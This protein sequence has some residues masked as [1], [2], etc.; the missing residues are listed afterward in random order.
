MSAVAAGPRAVRVAF[1]ARQGADPSRR[2]LGLTAKL[3]SGI[4]VASLFPASA[5]AAGPIASS[6]FIGT[7]D[8]LLENGAWAA[9]TSLSPNG[10]RFQKNNGAFPDKPGPD[11]A[12]A[13]T[14]AAVPVDQFSEIVVGHVG[15]TNNN[16]GPIVRVQASGPSIDSH[17]LWWTSQPNGVSGLYRIDANGTS[18]GSAR[19]LGSSSVVD[20]DRLRL[21][22]RGPVIYGV[23]NGARE[24][25]Y[26]TGPDTVKYSTGTTGMLAWAGNGVVTDSRI[27]SWSTDAAPVSLGTWA[28]S[29]FTGVE[30]PLDETDR[31]Y[32]LPGYSGFRKAGVA[33]GKDGAHTASGVWSIAP[34]AKQ[35]SEVTLGTVARGGGGP[36]VRIDRTNN[37]QTGWL[38]FLAPENLSLS[39][40]YKMNPDGSFTGVRLFTP[41]IV[42]GDKW[43]LT[44]DGNTLEAFRNGVSQFTYTTDGSYAAGD[45]GIEAYTS[46][47]TF[48]AWEG[49]DTGGGDA[50]PPSQP[51]NLGATAVS[52]SQINLGWT[53]S[54]DNV[55]VSG[56]LVERCP[57]NPCSA[58]FTQ[59]GTV[60]GTTTS[61]NDTGLAASTT[62]GYQV[63]ATDSAGNRSSYSNTASATTGVPVASAAGGTTRNGMIDRR[64]NASEGMRT[65][66]T[67][68]TA[69]PHAAIAIARAA[70]IPIGD[71][72]EAASAPMTPAATV[73][74]DVAR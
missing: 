11:H 43:R 30:D 39:G 65:A 72:T 51:T 19:I 1:A 32:P 12:G 25:I 13:R 14:T 46:A 10:G 33:I 70:M 57:G 7:E 47:F 2:R 49:G 37:G 3:L 71:A 42:S 58:S 52:A 5:I 73:T 44:A 34:P 66:A 55:G 31:W 9:L 61:Y 6:T 26:N 35:Y 59:V 36:V 24:F 20:G 53:A 69:M 40:I 67:M 45:V 54:T 56:Y 28:S 60:S 15:T 8:P 18:Y 41:A 64:E 16:V 62:Y 27:A 50:I 63:R 48:T 23:K 22:A 21:I 29:T 68:L 38:L 4:L 17:Y 74:R